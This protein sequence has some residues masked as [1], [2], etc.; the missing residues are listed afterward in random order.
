MGNGDLVP[1]FE[2][3]FLD[4]TLL[5]G[6]Y[7]KIRDFGG[8]DITRVGGAIIT[9]LDGIFSTDTTS[10]DLAKSV[11]FLAI[12]SHHCAERYF[13][14]PTAAGHPGTTRK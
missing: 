11:E 13:R 12:S 2:N 5:R 8:R 7:E 6:T 4:T 14:S 3:C 9:D 10:T 1:Y